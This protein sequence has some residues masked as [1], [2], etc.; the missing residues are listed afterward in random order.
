MF[1]ALLRDIVH[2][3]HDA[4]ATSYCSSTSRFYILPTTTTTM[5]RTTPYSTTTPDASDP[6]RQHVHH[7]DDGNITDD[8]ATGIV[9]KLRRLRTMTTNISR[10]IFDD[11]YDHVQ[12]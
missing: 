10:H 9:Y 3:V 7:E 1:I 11:D 4:G 12:S 6:D 5:D 2:N 8:Y